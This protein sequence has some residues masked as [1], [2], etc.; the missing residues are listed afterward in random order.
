MGLANIEMISLLVVLLSE[1]IP[2]TPIRVNLHFADLL[3]QAK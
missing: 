1:V 2:G 3:R